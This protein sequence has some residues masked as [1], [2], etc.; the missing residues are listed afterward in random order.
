MLNKLTLFF[1]FTSMPSSNLSV[2]M[3]MD[4]DRKIVLEQVRDRKLHLAD[5]S[6]FQADHEIVLASLRADFDSFSYACGTL[7]SDKGFMMKAAAINANA[8]SRAHSKLI[9]DSEVIFSAHPADAHAVRWASDRLRSDQSFMLLAVGRNGETLAFASDALQDD[10]QVVRMA[11]RQ[12]VH[13]L[14]FASN[15][16]KSNKNFVVS[17]LEENGS[18]L[19]YVDDLFRCD[20]N[21]V[22]LA[23]RNAPY[24][25]EYAA[26]DLQEDPDIMKAA[27][28]YL[29]SL[30]STEGEDEE[31]EGECGPTEGELPSSDLQ[32]KMAIT[33]LVG[34]GNP[35]NGDEEAKCSS[36]GLSI[37]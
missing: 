9:D 17:V 3:L 21:M 24:A 26:E 2:A 19:E 29:Q 11:F 36:P 8:L 35:S 1:S 20:K 32:A 4:M 18:A 37:Q 23:V 30:G 22:L 31:Q 6:N 15:A 16:L 27:E 25:L 12:T 5:L 7:M 34:G 28:Q 33:K 14:A 10:E 13:A